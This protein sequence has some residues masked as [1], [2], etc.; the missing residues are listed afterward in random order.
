MNLDRLPLSASQKQFF[1]FAFAGGVAFFVDVGI[2]A[3]LTRVFGVDPISARAVSFM[4]GLTTTW[5][6]NRSLAFRDRPA[7]PLWLEYVRYCAVNGTG[8]AI[9]FAVYTLC[10]ENIGLAARYPEIGVGIGVICGL[11]FNFTGSKYLV[12]RRFG[13]SSA[14]AEGRVEIDAAVD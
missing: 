10:V 11:G 3:L 5:L 6:I 8:G 14:A 2:L 13:K 1:L 7:Q 9:N 4:M 12:F